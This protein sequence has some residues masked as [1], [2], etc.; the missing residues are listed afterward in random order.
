MFFYSVEGKEILNRVIILEF[1][2][3]NKINNPRINIERQRNGDNL[4]K[5][6]IRVEDLLKDR[7]FK[8]EK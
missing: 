3:I 5:F 6:W 8:F 2:N 4:R 1:I 7:R